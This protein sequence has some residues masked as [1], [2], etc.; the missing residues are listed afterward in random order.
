M[1]EMISFLR[2]RIRSCWMSIDLKTWI[3]STAFADRDELEIQ[4]NAKSPL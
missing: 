3:R 1:S 4:H 2:K